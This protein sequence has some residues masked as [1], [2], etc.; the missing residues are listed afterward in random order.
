MLSGCIILTYDA[1]TA[2]LVAPHAEERDSVLKQEIS[3][4]EL[5]DDGH[6]MPEVQQCLPHL[7]CID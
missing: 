3:D 5:I 6:V 4:F 2:Q 7:L 1:A